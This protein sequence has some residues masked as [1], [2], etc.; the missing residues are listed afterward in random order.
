[1]KKIAAWI[2]LGIITIVAGLLLSMTNEVTK[3]VIATQ[4]AES[5][6]EARKTVLPDAETFEPVEVESLEP[7]SELF[8]G[9]KNGEAVGYVGAVSVNGYGGPV[10]IIA[11]VDNDGKVTGVSVG[12][13]EF[14]ETAGL[15]AKAKDLAFTDQFLMKQTP[16]KA[17]KSER[18]RG[19]N[20]VDAIAA[21]T[22]TTN[23][24]TS[25]VNSIA[26]KV[27]N[28]LNPPT[29]T[30]AEGTMYTASEQGFAGPVAVFV[31]VKDDGTISGL[32]VGDDAF[33]ET[34]GFGAAALE[35]SFT[36]GFVGLAL[37]LDAAQVDGISGATITTNAVVAAINRAY[38][39]KNIVEAPAAEGTTYTAA[40]Q[41]FAGPVA[42]FVTAKDDG[43]ITA[44][45]VGDDDF[46][47]TDG[48]GAPATEATFTN[49]FVGKTIP[50]ALE[51]IDALS[52]AT[53]TSTA[54]V[55]AINRAFDEKLVDESVPVVEPVAETEGMPEVTEEPEA[56][57]AEAT[58]APAEE[59]VAVE[60]TAV[61]FPTAAPMT[62]RAVLGTAQGYNGPIYAVVS[63]NA[64]NTIASVVVLEGEFADTP[65]IGDQVLAADYLAGFNGKTL[66]VSRDMVDAI[67]GATVSSNGVLDAVNNAMEQLV[68]V[69]QGA[70][71]VEPVSQMTG[72]AAAGDA[73]G[74]GGPIQVIVSLNA[75]NTIASI[76]VD[77]DAFAETPGIGD[78]VL[79]EEFVKAFEGLA[80]P[81][82][83]DAV[84]TISGSTV[85]SQAVIDAVNEAVELLIAAPSVAK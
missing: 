65:G 37:P 31:T 45:R 66:P 68:A 59:E 70:D 42:V 30:V 75:D 8:A 73:E 64:D 7:L 9:M 28:Y 16:V 36:K 60:E 1:M 43:T 53:V 57:A 2:A 12:G 82:Q 23:A 26:T 3:D 40:E 22:I 4:E 62:G 49:Q 24:V 33:A 18:D 21:A 54:V 55:N 44:L 76:Q 84:D 51:D 15:G 85:S 69:P 5:K 72:R 20:T 32:K 17:V 46:K 83:A 78:K 74:F 25:G 41:G 34:E 35:D 77:E 58:E 80:V 79:A 14:A 10:Q 61:A 19:D 56:E 38:D 27:D 6:V 81:L 47:E 63:L 13:A 67:A 71:A 48:F 52:G 50:V 29:D 39:E 11:G